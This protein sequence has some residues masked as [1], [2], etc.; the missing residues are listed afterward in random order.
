MRNILIPLCAFLLV[1][2]NLFSQITVRQVR[3]SDTDPLI[4]TFNSDSNYV[5]INT[6]VTPKNILVVYLPGTNGK[7]K[8]STYFG[9]AAAQLGFHSVGVVYPNGQA[10]ASICGNSSDPSCFE[11]VR[12]ETIEGVDYSSS[13][14]VNSTE[15]ILNRLKKLLVYLTSNYPLENWGQYLDIDGDVIFDKVIISGSSQGGGHAAL[16]GKYYPVKRVLCFSSP[17]DWSNFFNGPPSWLNPIGWQTTPDNIYGFNHTLDTYAATLQIWDSLGINNYGA[18]VNVDN[19][20]SPYNNTR[21][22][23]TSYPVPTGDEH[24]STAINDATPISSGLPVFL[25][26]WNYMLSYGLDT[27]TTG[28]YDNNISQLKT[29]PN[30]TNGIVNIDL[31]NEEFTI[32]VFDI[33]GQIAFI[34]KS[35]VGNNKVDLSNLNSGIYFVQVMGDKKIFSGK[36][37][38]L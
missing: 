28:I 18:P 24:G 23:I 5:Y 22:L 21:Q 36:I 16:I 11:N 35:K 4:S 14:S 31:P 9:M 8:N 33:T 3:P 34:Q 17:K 13:V 27:L 2:I 38:K 1:S 19:T 29:F 37:L 30:P 12:R 10:V 6:N 25:P 20:S 26:V 15:C 32:T 7:P